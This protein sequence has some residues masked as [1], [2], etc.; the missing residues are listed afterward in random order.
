MKVKPSSYLKELTLLFVEDEKSVRE[1]FAKLISNKVKKIFVASNGK[2]GLE[3]FITEK[4]DI[5]ISDIRMPVMDGLEMAEKIKEISPETPVIFVTAFTD[6]EYLLEALNI[7]AEG[8]ITKPVNMNILYKKLN[9]IA[10]NI[11]NKRRLQELTQILEIVLNEYSNPVLLLEN[12][13]I[14]LYNRAFMEIFGDIKDIDDLK[15]RVLQEDE[16]QN[17][18]IEKDKSIICI[19]KN[20]L[21]TYFEVNIKKISKFKILYF[22][23]IT[24]YRKKIFIDELT[25]VYN[26][27]F[28][29]ILEKKV[30]GR[31]VCLIMCDVDNFKQINDTYGHQT[32]DKVLREIG[33]TLNRFLRKN[34]VVIRYGGEEFLILLDNVENIE[35]TF[36]IAEN[37]RKKIKSISIKDLNISCSLGVS[38]KK[39]INEKEFQEL[40][41]N[42]DVALYKAKKTG[43]DKTEKK[44]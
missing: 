7:G 1:V 43:K 41:K 15:N 34:D 8:Y 21:K 35:T 38:C 39:I 16:C 22:I 29:K 14:K 13:K 20:N 23:D 30:V 44:L 36:A 32:G 11:I 25:G 10:E 2:E 17:R 33:K 5:V 19:S 3:I 24:E 28:L 40:I 37:I 27:Y 31:T 9:F 4:P 6:V 18:F 26:R 12:N 42:A